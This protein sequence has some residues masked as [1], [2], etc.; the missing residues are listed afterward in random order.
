[1]GTIATQGGVRFCPYGAGPTQTFLLAYSVIPLA[2][3]HEKS[4]LLIA[5]RRHIP[6][7]ADGNAH[8]S[9]A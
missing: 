2:V 7:V 8:G 3:M 6:R 5:A 1:M 4:P 9:G